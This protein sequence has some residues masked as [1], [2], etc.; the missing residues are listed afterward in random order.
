[1]L[2]VRQFRELNEV[3]SE[4]LFEKMIH[5]VSL[6][7]E[8][9]FD[10]VA[11]WR[12][13]RLTSE[14]DKIKKYVTVSE[15][16]K[17]EIELQGKRLELIDFNTM[18]LGQFIDIETLITQGFYQNIHKIA[19]SIY[20]TFE[21]GDLGSNTRE[22]YSNVNINYRAELI[23]ELPCAEIYGACKKL[24]PFRDMFFSSYSIFD[25]EL[26]NVKVEELDDEEL[27]IYNE[28]MKQREQNR[29]SQWLMIL[30]FISQSDITKFETILNTNL[31][32]V[33][34]QLTYLK[35]QTK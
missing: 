24:L 3:E 30:N 13:K 22:P 8:L 27:Q 34:N 12:T 19:S 9:D 10:E 21:I 15:R 28:E 2:T 6:I 32:M 1:M 35:N 18:T 14:Y 29:D 20:M 11:N 23:D 26:K 7:R 16:F 17:N 33:F 25:D 31:F 4:G 5:S